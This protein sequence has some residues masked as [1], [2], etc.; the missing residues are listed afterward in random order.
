MKISER[1]AAWQKE[2]RQIEKHR[3]ETQ[4]RCG[5][6]MMNQPYCRDCDYFKSPWKSGLT[7][8]SLAIPP[9]ELMRTKL[10]II[11]AIL[12]RWRQEGVVGEEKNAY[13][14]LKEIERVMFGNRQDKFKWDES[15]GCFRK[16]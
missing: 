16:T 10:V 2:A 8:E 3:K 11:G 5:V 4:H 9:F 7:E 13:D 1:A 6:S 15:E 14:Y 12:E